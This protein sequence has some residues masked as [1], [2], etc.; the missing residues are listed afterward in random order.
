MTSKIL[1]T[2]PV[3]FA[4]LK[5]TVK[6][7]LSPAFISA[8][9]AEKVVSSGQDRKTS[10]IFRGAVPLFLNLNWWLITSPC[11]AEPKSKDA[12]SITIDGLPSE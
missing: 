2:L 6:L 10:P 5:V 11:F 1:L 3:K 12:S 9:L 7:P 4:V 8:E